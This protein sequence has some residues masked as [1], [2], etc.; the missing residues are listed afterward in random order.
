MIARYKGT[1]DFIDNISEFNTIVSVARSVAN[2]YGYR[3]WSTPIIEYKEVFS[4]NIGETTDIV[5]KE[6]FELNVGGKDLILRPEGTASIVRALLSN[7]LTQT[8]PRKVFYQGPMFRYEN[9]QLG[10]FRQFNQIGCE[11]LGLNEIENDAE[12]ISLAKDILTKLGINDYTIRINSFGD[13]E[14][15]DKWREA[16]KKY[17]SDNIDKLSEISQSNIEKNVFR[18]LDSKNDNDKLL[19]ESAPKIIDFFTESALANWNKLLETLSLFDVEYV[20]DNT[21]V[22][23]LDYYTSTIFEFT[24][25]ELGAQNTILAGGRYDSLIKSMGGPDVG[26]VGFAA[27]IERLMLLLPKSQEVQSKKKYVISPISKDNMKYCIQFMNAMRE[28]GFDV[29][30]SYKNN[31]KKRL[32]YSTKINASYLVI[33]GDN[34]IDNKTIQLKD[35]QQHS[36][37]TISVDQFM[38]EYR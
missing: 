24:T 23:G 2:F 28:K 13:K 9:P 19:S 27:G 11:L 29:E 6:M 34:E 7:S 3:E 30:I 38:K 21:I 33:I 20:I 16:L 32:S 14:S 18:I 31:L 22:R 37:V 10:R 8:L 26:A 15:K 36:Q 17:Y 12:M 35:L 1:N 4:K 25:N 5:K